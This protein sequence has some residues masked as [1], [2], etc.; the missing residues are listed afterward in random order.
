MVHNGGFYANK[1]CSYIRAHDCRSD[2]LRCGRCGSISSSYRTKNAKLR[3]EGY[4]KNAVPS[5]ILAGVS[6]E[7]VFVI[8]LFTAFLS[9]GNGNQVT[10]QDFISSQY[11]LLL[12]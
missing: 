2:Y 4:E 5:L 12:G 10:T 3:E 1:S 9:L 6:E 11:Q 8:V 7:D